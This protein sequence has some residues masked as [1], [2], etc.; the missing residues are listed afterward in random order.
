MV[1]I[2]LAWHNCICFQMYRE[3]EKNGLIEDEGIHNKNNVIC[4]A[5]TRVGNSFSSRTGTHAHR[6][7]RRD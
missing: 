5:T 4:G 2:C 7:H 3:V 6:A 1:F